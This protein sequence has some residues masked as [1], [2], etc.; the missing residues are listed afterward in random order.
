MRI[1]HYKL[2]PFL[3]KSQLLSQKRECDLIWKHWDTD[4][5]VNH[6]LINYIY[7]HDYNFL[8][9]YYYALQKEFNKRNYKF[10]DNCPFLAIHFDLTFCE[11]DDEYLT[12]CYWN[13]REKYIRGQKDFTKEIWDKLDEFYKKEIGGINEK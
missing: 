11:H 4:K 9:S 8:A 1:W 6:I 7:K 13:L 2:L 10:N 5:R 12:I 3:P